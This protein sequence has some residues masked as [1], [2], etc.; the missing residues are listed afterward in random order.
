[1]LNLSSFGWPLICA[2]TLK[3]I[4]DILLLIQFRA[5]KPSDEE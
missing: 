2:G 1:M 5:V 3:A 4:Y